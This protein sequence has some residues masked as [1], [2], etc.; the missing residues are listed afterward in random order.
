MKRIVTLLVAS[1]L[2]SGCLQPDPRTV[3]GIQ[4]GQTYVKYFGD[5]APAGAQTLP[6]YLVIRYSKNIGER[7][8]F[9]NGSKVGDKFEYASNLMR[10][11]LTDVKDFLR[12]GDNSMLIEPLNLARATNLKFRFDSQGPVVQPSSA[13]VFGDSGCSAGNGMVSVKLEAYD[14]SDIASISL[15]DTPATKVDGQWVVETS[16]N[17]PNDIFTIVARDENG[18]EE[19]TRYLKDGANISDVFK[20]KLGESALDGMKPLINDKMKN[21]RLDAKALSDVGLDNVLYA[22]DAGVA[23]VYIRLLDIRIGQGNLNSFTFDKSVSN[24]IGLDMHMQPTI[25]HTPDNGT[26]SG[27]KDQVGTYAKV[28]IITTCKPRDWYESKARN[29]E[30]GFCVTD[31]GF[32]EL[33]IESMDVTGDVDL[34]LA[35]GQFNV[36]L[37]D[38]V[39]IT[40]HDTKALASADNS[41]TGRLISSL[42]ASLKD[43]GILKSAMRALIGGVLDNNLKQIRIGMNFKNDDGDNFDLVTFAKTVTTDAN[44]MYMA[45]DGSLAVRE[46]PDNVVR[47]LGSYY[48]DEPLGDYLGGNSNLQVNVNSNLINQGLNTLYSIGMTHLTLTFADTK[49]HFGPDKVGSDYGKDG[50]R[51]MELVP[52]GPGTIRFYGSTTNQAAI[53]YR[54]AKMRVFDKKDG[55]WEQVF[56]ADVDISAGVLMRASDNVFKMTINQTPNIIVNDLEQTGSLI[57]LGGLKLKVPDNVLKEIILG[58][59]NLIYPF[60]SETELSIDIPN[61]DIEGSPVIGKVTTDDFS[62]SSGHLKFTMG[63]NAEARE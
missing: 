5:D 29:L 45:Y 30:F 24:R 53:D 56:Y 34:R 54:N 35:D 51:K 18:M 57:H 58:G 61:V 36:D 46:A 62:T 22:M 40:M 50:D 3:E 47:S 43:S 8:V 19:T 2:L 55:E 4:N 39:D 6:E 28:Q 13:C 25:D 59:L 31:W 38:S 49:V 26:V 48:I 44:S 11:R 17:P 15:N 14:A 9:L 41:L 10:L 60:L 33:L 12:Q 37:L 42:A 20:L 21:I 32:A 1:F 7:Q 27:D 23:H 63:V 16:Y 52:A